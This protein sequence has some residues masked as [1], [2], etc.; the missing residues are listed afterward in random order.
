MPETDVH[1]VAGT[2]AA[3]CLQSGLALS[4]DQ[5]LVNL[6]VLSCGPLPPLDSLERWRD[7]RESYLRS[8]D[9]DDM[10]FSFAEDDRDLL[11]NRERLRSAETITLW[12][13]TG[14]AE[15]LLMVWV[16]TLLR[17]LDVDAGRCRIVQF[18]FDRGHEV[19]A[20]GVIPP[21]RF[22]EH[23]PAVTLT[24][25]AI[26]EATR[27]WNAVTCGFTASRP[28]FLGPEPRAQFQSNACLGVGN[29]GLGWMLE[30]DS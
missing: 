1:V 2:S 24:D 23:P 25:E 10:S 16:I 15:Q 28:W 7:V 3:A 6:D 22:K 5:L 20:M 26:Q 21:S 11:T 17:R 29:L 8:L 12:L 27:A 13:G 30:V 4:R 18:G 19:I 9:I 14:L